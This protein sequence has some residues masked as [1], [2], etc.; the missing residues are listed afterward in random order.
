MSA[1]QLIK[2]IWAIDPVHTKFRFDAKYLMLTT[3]TGWFT[4][5]EGTAHSIHDDFT[6]SEIWITIY[7]NSIFTGI[8]ERDDHL[9]SGD[10][11]DA[12]RYPTIKFHSDNFQLNDKGLLIT[13]ELSIK[14]VTRELTFTAVYLGNVT[15]PLGNI[16]ACFEM[17]TVFNRKDFDI[18]WNQFFD[19][20]GVLIS[21][22]VKFHADIQLLRLSEMVAG[23]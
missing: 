3:V 2:T 7:T 15:D 6:G 22:Q 20:K 11:F 19:E 17:D 23:S 18:S 10:F 14:E 21:D 9:R 13:G 4:E 16:K 12:K 8:T 1:S 5:V